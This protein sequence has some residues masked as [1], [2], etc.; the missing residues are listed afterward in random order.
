MNDIE[1]E[2][3]RVWDLEN[4]ALAHLPTY[5]PFPRESIVGLVMPLK[6]LA[7]PELVLFA[8]WNGKTVGWFPGIPDFNE[9]L[10]HLNGL[11]YPWDY[12]RALRYYRKKPGTVSIK[13]V[14]VPPEYW[15]SGVAVLLF[16]EMAR[17]VAAK[18]YKRVEFSLTSE[19][20]PDTWDLAHHVGAR[21]YKRYR[22]YRKPL[23]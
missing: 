11:R 23:G 22:F 8:E 3:D 12:L 21:I 17:R 18:G 19:E 16:D 15:D 20:N 10:I 1:G 5:V 14:V 4:R 13:S 7:D 9:I 6:D 2:I